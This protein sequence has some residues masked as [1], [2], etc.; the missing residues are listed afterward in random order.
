MSVFI[1]SH[2][3]TPAVCTLIFLGDVIHIHGSMYALL[4]THDSQLLIFTF[5]T[6]F[7][8]YLFS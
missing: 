4:C 7:S 8:M 2:A 3:Q 6:V 1:T 5:L